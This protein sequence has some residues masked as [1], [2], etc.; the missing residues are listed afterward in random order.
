LEEEEGTGTK[1][2][3]GRDGVLGE[4]VCEAGV[5]VES[6]DGHVQYIIPCTYPYLP[7]IG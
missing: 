1:K 4:D 6:I 5:V 7:N 2:E 3:E